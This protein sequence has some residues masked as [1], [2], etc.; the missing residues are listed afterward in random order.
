MY[1]HKVSGP[2][3][4]KAVDMDLALKRQLLTSHISITKMRSIVAYGAGPILGLASGP[5]LAR[6]MGP[7]GRGQF[8]AIMQPLTLAGALASIGIPAAATYFVAK[9]DFSRRSILTR[10]LILSSL[11]ALMAYG[12]LYVYSD[13]LSQNLGLGRGYLLA[14]WSLVFVLA[15]VQIVRGYIQG[16]AG[17]RILDSERFIFAVL[18]FLGVA[19]LA[20]A[21]VSIAENYALAALGAF[22]L[23]AFVLI[24]PLARDKRACSSSDVPIPLPILTGYSLSAALGTIAV[25]ANNRLDQVLLPLASSTHEV[26]FYAVAVTVA[27]VPLILGTL[28]ARDAL[29]ESSA[30]K[31]AIQI[32]KSCGLYLFSAIGLSIAL[33][34]TAPLYMAPVFG[35]LFAEAIRSVQ[36]LCLGTIFACIALVLTSIISGMGRPGVSSFIPLVGL[37]VTISL[38][39]ML[40]DDMTSI[41][42]AAIACLSQLASLVVG[43]ALISVPR[44][45][46]KSKAKHRFDE[47]V[48]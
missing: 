34:L 48:V 40:Q 30:G 31:P 16:Q 8:A 20:I 18:R 38:F 39:Y 26:G 43:I 46:S 36:I 14:V 1:A 37:V 33:A 47:Q 44:S 23:A 17:W 21:G 3:Y 4:D 27:E 19:I 24:I 13:A 28:A 2:S 32:L 45:K 25:V 12:V 6:A 10:G 42:A 29:F 35:A 41:I 7:E 15:A 9:G 11:F 22:V 5:L